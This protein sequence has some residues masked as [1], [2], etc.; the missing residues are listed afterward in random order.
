MVSFK[1]FYTGDVQTEGLKQLASAGLLAGALA[2]SPHV[3]VG[4]PNDQVERS[5]AAG[6]IERTQPTVTV[7]T[8]SSSDIITATL[9]G[10]AGGE[11]VTGMHAVLNVIMNRA[12]GNYSLARSI[13][14]KRKQFSMWNNAPDRARVVANA[15]KHPQWAEAVALV[16]QARGGAL[17]DITKGSKL[18]Y[19]QNKVTPYWAD[20]KI[21]ER[22]EVIG[23]HTFG[24]A[25]SAR[26]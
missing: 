21:F 20:P 25:K 24:R 19:A 26:K 5:V 14:L 13:C 10:E 4:K 1:Q 9:I 23:N 11:G 8:P 12:K 6:P 16:N 17:S 15:R 22:K 7:N 18:Y 3:A 2:M